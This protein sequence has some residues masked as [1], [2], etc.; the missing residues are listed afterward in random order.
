[1]SL[2]IFDRKRDSQ[3]FRDVSIATATKRRRHK[4]RRRKR[5]A[6]TFEPLEQRRVLS[7]PTNPGFEDTPD[8]VGWTVETGFH[9][10]VNVSRNGTG[11][12]GT[13]H[14]YLSRNE[15]ADPSPP[16]RLT[17]SIFTAVAGETIEVDWT[18]RRARSRDAL[19]RGVLRHNNNNSVTGTFFESEFDGDPYFSDWSTAD[20]TVPSTGTYYLEFEIEA[21]YAGYGETHRLG[22]D[23][24]RSDTPPTAEAG[25]P[26]EVY[27]G[28]S[29]D[30]TGTGSDMEGPVSFAWDLNY[31]GS[32]NLD[33]PGSVVNF[34]AA[35]IDGDDTR[36]VA[37]RVTDTFGH[38]TLDTAT[39]EILNADPTNIT[40]SDSGPVNEGDPL[41]VTV[42]ATDPAGTNDPLTYWFDFNNDSTYEISNTTGIGQHVYA[43][44]GTFQVNVHVTDG[45]G[46]SDTA[47]TTVTVNNA[48][49]KFTSVAITPTEID[50]N[51]VATLNGVLVDPGTQ[52]PHTVTIDWGDGSPVTPIDMPAGVLVFSAD[53]TY[54]D[55]GQSPGN[56]IPTDVYT[57]TATVADDAEPVSEWTTLNPMPQARSYA[58]SAVL[59]DQIYTIGGQPTGTILDVYN[60]ASDTWTSRASMQLDRANLLACPST[61][62]SMPWAG[63]SAPTTTATRINSKCTIRFPILGFQDTNAH[64]P[65]S[66]NR[67]GSCREIVCRERHGG[68]F[69]EY[70]CVGDLR[71]GFEHLDNVRA[72][73]MF[74]VLIGRCESLSDCSCPQPSVL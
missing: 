53:H 21:S 8:L 69:S 41:A 37:L 31:D 1:M 13:A 68:E 33:A 11:T 3:G 47:S 10:G 38:E 51:G 24:I 27:E 63:V 45:D 25:G 7:V 52:D 4:A 35:A 30:L 2:H 9:V 48:A 28:D 17:S 34:P 39:V 62:I 19:F 57:I 18:A 42:T 44:D 56:G 67:C 15:P 22:V 74:R 49:P 23:N 32:F 50:E 40:V 60:P 6:F 65:G 59:D 16:P 61:E 58:A 36:T 26:Y 12:E 20:V 55:D 71:P 46:G 43:D 54:V 66:S 29:I 72:D 70:R 14:A 73:S 64:K 5:R